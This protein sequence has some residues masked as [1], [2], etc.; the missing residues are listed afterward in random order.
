MHRVRRINGLGIIYKAFRIIYKAFQKNERTNFS[1]IDLP[2]F[3][4]LVDERNL[5]FQSI[6]S[7]KWMFF[8]SCLDRDSQ[9]FQMKI[10]KNGDNFLMLI[11]NQFYDL[12]SGDFKFDVP[13]PNFLVLLYSILPFP[14]F[15]EAVIINKY[16]KMPF[17]DYL[18][19]FNVHTDIQV[20]TRCL[21]CEPEHVEA[22]SSKNYSFLV[23]QY[24]LLDERNQADF[25]LRAVQNN[26]AE[27]LYKLNIFTYF[28]FDLFTIL[29]NEAK[30]DSVLKLLYEESF[31]RAFDGLNE[32]DFFMNVEKIAKQKCRVLVSAIMVDNTQ[33]VLSFPLDIIIAKTFFVWTQ[34]IKYNAIKCFQA[35]FQFLFFPPTDQIVTYIIEQKKIE[36][37]KLILSIDWF[38]NVKGNSLSCLK[39]IGLHFDFFNAVIASND[40]EY[41]KLMLGESFQIILTETQIEKLCQTCISTTI[42]EMVFTK[43]IP[44]TTCKIISQLISEGSIAIV[45]YLFVKGKHFSTQTYSE[46]FIQAAEH[47]HIDFLQW[48]STVYPIDQ[49]TINV[50]LTYTIERRQYETLKY[51]L[52]TYSFKELFLL[53][54]SKELEFLF[55][56]GH[57]DMIVLLFRFGVSL[58]QFHLLRILEYPT[59]LKGAKQRL[60]LYCYQNVTDYLPIEMWKIISE[61]GVNDAEALEL[62]G[63]KHA[64]D[65]VV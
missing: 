28:D 60:M 34:I 12:A 54:L 15:N 61:F 38:S 9:Y 26:N 17:F 30:Y 48:M 43:V 11:L 32:N 20:I 18:L 46:A 53:S 42:Y 29:S 63:Y 51:L 37:F 4:S 33:I 27:H 22:N 6:E 57:Y 47:N 52:E 59:I 64:S 58:P 16:K 25:L 40:M 62:V 24:E 35:L 13:P 5:F 65:F 14:F 23:E 55:N 39:S 10:D 36:M 2:K 19:T 3:K 1:I 7:Q 31:L 49:F 56:T 8:L 21:M 44:S 45:Q 50:S 41:I